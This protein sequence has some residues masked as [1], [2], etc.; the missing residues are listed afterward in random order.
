MPLGRPARRARLGHRWQGRAEPDALP[1]LAALVGRRRAARLG[2]GQVP[3]G[4]DRGPWPA[5]QLR[6]AAR[7]DRPADQGRRG[8]RADTEGHADQS[9]RPAGGAA[10]GQEVSKRPA[11]PPKPRVRWAEL[12]LKAVTND[13]DDAVF[14]SSAYRL[15]PDD[16]QTPILSDW[17]SRRRDGKWCYGRCGLAVPRQNGKNGVIEI[18]ELWGMVVLGEAILH[19][20]HEVKTTRKAFKRLQHFFGKKAND[21]DARFPDL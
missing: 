18:R 4:A 2:R 11:T 13:V 21:P 5:G 19:A 3:V 9:S 15:I 20:A 17:L 12:N 14:L 16:W 6:G 8:A 7:G 10:Q 1:A